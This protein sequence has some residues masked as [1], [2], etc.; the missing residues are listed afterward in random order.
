[1]GLSAMSSA[2]LQLT[3]L[4]KIKTYYVKCVILI[5]VGLAIPEINLQPCVTVNTSGT[6]LLL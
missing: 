1:M 4:C 2:D 6:S 3:S 5:R